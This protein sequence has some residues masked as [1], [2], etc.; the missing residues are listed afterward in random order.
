MKFRER[1]KV[2]TALDR[3]CMNQVRLHFCDYPLQFGH[4]RLHHQWRTVAWKGSV[5]LDQSNSSRQPVTW[6]RAPGKAQIEDLVTRSRELLQ[7]T[8]VMIR[9]IVCEIQDAHEGQ[10]SSKSVHRNISPN[11]RSCLSFL[12]TTFS[13]S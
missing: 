5:T 6:V 3:A 9:V 8:P 2:S 10:P 7:K 12:P 4:E 1:R 13:S 11:E